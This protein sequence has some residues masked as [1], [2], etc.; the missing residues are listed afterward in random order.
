MKK[1]P[2]PHSPLDAL[3]ILQPSNPLQPSKKILTCPPPILPPLFDDL[4][5]SNHAPPHEPPLCTPRSYL[6]SRSDAT[7]VRRQH[8]GL[9]K[10][11]FQFDAFVAASFFRMRFYGLEVVRSA[12][13]EID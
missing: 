9:A 5:P 10:A 1:S 6:S 2:V 13:F 11:V 7:A 3:P 12:D 4:I 8:W